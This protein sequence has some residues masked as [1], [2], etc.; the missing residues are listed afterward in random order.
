QFQAEAELRRAAAEA[1]AATAA[2]SRFLAAVSHD[3]RQPLQVLVGAHSG[4][5]R[6]VKGKPA[7]E[8]KLALSELATERLVRAVDKLAQLSKLEGG[9]LAPNRQTFPIQ[10]VLSEIFDIN[11]QQARERALKFTVA[12]SDAWVS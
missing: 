4:L 10:T 6:A 8:K 9:A 2:K 7:Y 12:A 3:L 11:K 1:K 5:R